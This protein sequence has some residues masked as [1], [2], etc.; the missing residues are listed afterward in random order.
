MKKLTL[1]A[2]YAIIISIL[3][4]GCES[5]GNNFSIP[6]TPCKESS[7]T[8]KLLCYF[9]GQERFSLI[10]KLCNSYNISDK[11]EVIPEFVPYK[12]FLKKLLTDYAKNEIPDIVIYDKSDYAY[13]VDQ[14]ILG[15]ITK[16]INNWP[17]FT[18]YYERSINNCMINGRIYGL[19]IGENCLELFY[20]RHMLEKQNIK[21]P[22]TW[23]ELRK[24]AEK[25]TINDIKGI[26]ISAQNSEEGMFQFLPFLFSSGADLDRLDS[27]EAVKAFSFISQMVQAGYMSKETVNW[28]QADLMK[29]FAQEKIAMM[30]NGPW[31]I[32]ELKKKSPDLDYGVVKIPR[33][34]KWVTILGG[35]NISVTKGKNR[36]KAL[37][38]IKFFC[39]RDN[40]KT[41]TKSI[42]Y[43]PSR[44][45]VAVDEILTSPDVK[46]F[47][48][49]VQK[50]VSRGLDPKWPEKSKIVTNAL[51]KVILQMESP[52]S[53]A[54]EAQADIKRLSGE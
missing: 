17:E 31:Q 28:S 10:N 8:M 3:L 44:K 37:N 27:A 16:E 5:N 29:Q 49:E 36:Y 54:A 32:T 51:S 40:V 50:A 9:E 53:G 18:M 35:E 47:G 19:P 20:N 34:K 4:I 11:A 13:L 46:V 6:A 43:F 1:Y 42:G 24:A 22:E 14:D 2:I 23:D 39:R 26:G 41:F 33:N 48:E 21:P 12:D 38:F 7:R 15:D 45:D 52:E 25:L 30:I